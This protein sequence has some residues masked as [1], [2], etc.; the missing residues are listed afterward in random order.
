MATDAERE[1]ILR[2]LNVVTTWRTSDAPPVSFDPGSAAS[3]FTAAQLLTPHSDIHGIEASHIVVDE[4][5]DTLTLESPGGHDL[6]PG[7]VSVPFGSLP[8]AYVIQGPTYVLNFNSLSMRYE[9]AEAVTTPPTMT[10]AEVLT[11]YAPSWQRPRTRIYD[12]LPL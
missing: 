7:A 9:F 1:R 3:D 11:E 5:Q 6:P 2:D 4:L 10:Y 12:A 8:D